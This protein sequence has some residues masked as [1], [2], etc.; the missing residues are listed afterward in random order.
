LAAPP[1]HYKMHA[2]DT[3]F[4]NVWAVQL[5]V[6]WDV[7]NLL[8]RLFEMWGHGESVFLE[9]IVMPL[10]IGAYAHSG[11]RSSYGNIGGEFA[12]IA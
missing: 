8:R 12:I 1:N 11:S 3:R 9:K 7:G 10:R 5:G 2:P 6:Q 4:G